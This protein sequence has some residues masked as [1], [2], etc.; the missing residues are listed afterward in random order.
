MPVATEDARTSVTE[1]IPQPA[2]LRSGNARDELLKAASRLMNVRDTIE[3]SLSEIAA[4]A[5][6]NAALVKYHFGNKRGLMVALAEMGVSSSMRQLNALVEADLDPVEKLRLH[7]AGVLRVSFRYR[8]MNRLIRALLRDSTPD[9]A[10]DISDRLIRPAAEAQR[11]I[12]AQGEASGVFR[13]VDPMLFYLTVMGACDVFFL[14][15]S[16]LRLVFD[17]VQIDDKLL[18]KL[19]DHTSAIIL[20]GIAPD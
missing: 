1:V 12:L 14:S 13:K 2:S 3:I 10:R 8:Y 7:L 18:Q 6:V 20:R 16:T 4:E 9:Q 17:G 19:T 5:N 11:R 15:E